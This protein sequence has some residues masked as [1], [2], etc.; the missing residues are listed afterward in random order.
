MQD[1]ITHIDRVTVYRNGALVVR[2]GEAVAGP[3]V[4]RGLPLLF[5]SD[6]LRVRAAS[7]A[8]TAIRESCTVVGTSPPLPAYLDDIQALDREHMRLSDEGNGLESE[9][10]ALAQISPQPLQ[11][12]EQPRVVDT[13]AW[14]SLLR[15]TSDLIV[16]K[17]AALADVHRRLREVAVARAKV[18]ALS[19]GDPSPPRFSRAL[20]FDL[21]TKSAFELEYFVAAARWVPTYALHLRGKNAELVVA[22]MVAQASGESWENVQLA[23]STADLARDTTLPELTSW[24]IGRAQP[25]P[26]RA[27]RPLPNDLPTLF[28]GYDASSRA[29]ARSPERL[30]GPPP[31][32]SSPP[33]RA[34]IRKAMADDARD[35]PFD[36]AAKTGS[37]SMRD[38]SSEAL[39]DDI[40]D[41]QSRD[42][43]APEDDSEWDE[44]TPLQSVE[45]TASRMMLG[46]PPAPAAA[47]MER[48]RRAPAAPRAGGPPS[49]SVKRAQPPLP[50]RLRYAYTRLAGPDE[51]QRGTLV[52]L[53]VLQRLS[54]FVEAHDVS[55]VDA[56][57]RAVTTLIDAARR[58]SATPL[59]PMTHG[60]GDTFSATVFRSSSLHTIPDDGAFW[61]VQAERRASDSVLELRTVPREAPEVYRFCVLPAPLT[62]LPSG[63]LAVFED[64]VF[65]V[66]TTLDHSARGGQALEIN[67]GVDTDVRV[68][69]RVVHV[70]Q[71][72]KGLV[73]QTSRITH[74]VKT[75]IRSTA[76][77]HRDVFVYDR[78]PVADDD[79]KD[80]KVELVESKPPAKRSERGPDG[81]PLKG[82]LSW[83]LVVQPGSTETIEARYTIDLPAKLELVGGNRRE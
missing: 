29:P 36:G 37:V 42:D 72:E 43:G 66:T 3:V 6:S 60:L 58:L 35:A 38:E 34:S 57:R 22:A 55:A 44:A 21:D 12:I 40:L 26:R 46:A 23:F 83:R 50:P 64:D 81:L 24:R 19:T 28:A 27:F 18:M 45:L 63:P 76:S 10:E 14:A 53:D 48:T 73:S 71:D 20:E 1:V 80:I 41:D 77:A 61:R 49:S 25:V 16:A 7:G 51:A 2:R 13:G 67:L 74:T 75:T 65:R 32:P 15:E 5:S 82:A 39:I 17:R 59:P 52:A 9:I 11:H 79:V 4:V 8:V 68:M 70:H 54:W 47:S 31:P 30:P 62:P 56:L 69:G 33:P 78:L